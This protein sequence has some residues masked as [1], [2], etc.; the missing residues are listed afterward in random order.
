MKDLLVVTHKTKEIKGVYTHNDEID[1]DKRI[2]LPDNWFD[3]LNSLTRSQRRSIE[4]E[5]FDSDE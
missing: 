3:N 1:V 2:K 4:D 5:S